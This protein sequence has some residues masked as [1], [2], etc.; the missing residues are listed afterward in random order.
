MSEPGGEAERRPDKP[1]RSTGGSK[2]RTLLAEQELRL[3]STLVLLLGVGLFLALPFVLSIG[4]V[5]FLPVTAAVLLTVLLAPLADRLSSWGVPN[6]LAS[7]LALVI[8]V[9]IV[10][11]AFSAILQPAFS[12]FDQLP[13]LIEQIGSR[14]RE[15]QEEF[16]WLANA[17]ERLADLV[18]GSGA[19][20][21]TLAGPSVFQQVA[22]SAP[23]LLLE[24]MLTFLMAFFMVEARGRLRRNI[25][26]GR[27][28]FGT[29]VKAARVLREVQ[30][31]VA[32]Y[33]LTVAWINL[34]VGIV[35][36][37][38]AWAMG[39]PA[40]IMWGGLATLLNFIPYVGPLAMT[41]LLV[42]F[43]LGTADS[44]FLGMIPAVAYITLHVFEANAIT[45][46]ILGRRFTM[47]PVMILLAFSYFTW[48][49]GAIG[50]LLS[51]P[52][53]LMLTAFFDHVGRP[54][55]L[56]F[57]FGEP[58]FQTPLIE[59]ADESLTPPPKG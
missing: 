12:L 53:L 38:G 36:A 28:S 41:G 7:V 5:V 6:T 39:L 2:K 46:A 57:I 15:M 31:R 25:L 10:V 19:T 54:N 51:V 29:S 20:E 26:F 18:G 45:P 43:G 1:P 32:A 13:E 30:D 9:A 37:L 40:P 58:L 42:L 50:A 17:N 23:V 49:W 24:V 44:V 56:G 21:V 52:L 3:L 8:F 4:S 34:G 59:E 55:L 11:L 16:A 47:N 27:T 14:Y 48:I 22:I 35:V 33:I